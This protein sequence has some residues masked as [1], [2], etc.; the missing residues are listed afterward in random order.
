MKIKTEKVLPKTAREI[1]NGGVYAQRVRCGK[2]NCHCARAGEM[3]TAFY[4][5]SRHNGKQQKLYIRKA[6]VDAF[7]EMVSQS[8]L[9]RRQR[10]Q[11]AKISAE[12]LREVRAT[13]RENDGLIKTLR[14]N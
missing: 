11:T 8:A 5:L 7:A 6:E 4:F 1:Q 3:H 9:E 12:F 13:L 2:A 10:R 14:E